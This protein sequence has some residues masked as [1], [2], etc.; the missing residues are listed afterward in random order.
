MRHEVLAALRSRE[1]RVS[2]QVLSDELGISRVAVWKQIQ[3]LCAAGYGVSVSPRGYRLESSPDLLLA[4][5]FPGWESRV[6]HFHVADSTMHHARELA[7]AGAEEGTLII[8]EQ[9]SAGRGRLERS[10]LSPAGGIYMTLVTRPAVAPAQAPRMNLLAAVAVSDAIERLF[11]VPA[12]VKWPNDVLIEGRKVCGILAE[13]EAE[14]DAVRFVNVGIGLNAN[15][16]IADVQEGA[17][18][19]FELLGAPVDRVRLVR[20]IVAGVLSRLP[21][22]TDVTTLD[23]WRT[24][25]VTIGREVSVVT[26]DTRIT[27][28]AVDINSTGALLVRGP[29]GRTHEVVAGDCI[30]ASI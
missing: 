27:G 11:G 15:M 22:L 1:G 30:H 14:T 4:T 13:M 29:D 21:R 20:E 17:V 18:S 8:A 28:V 7:R 9:Q 23:E 2:G 6:H 25:A 10:W 3:A 16:P 19:L 12:R 24:R 5:E 26:G